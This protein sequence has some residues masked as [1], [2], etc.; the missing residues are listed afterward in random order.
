MYSLRESPPMYQTSGLPASTGPSQ[1][2]SCAK[3]PSAVRFLGVELGA[4]G[5][6]S[7]TQPNVL[8]TLR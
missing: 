1:A 5:S 6:I 3:R 7:T 2:P 8:A 4:N